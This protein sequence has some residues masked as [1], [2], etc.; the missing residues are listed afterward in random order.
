MLKL[1][2]SQQYEPLEVDQGQRGVTINVTLRLSGSVNVRSNS[3]V[4]RRDQQST[5]PPSEQCG[6]DLHATLTAFIAR[7]SCSLLI[8]GRWNQTDSRTRNLLMGWALKISRAYHLPRSHFWFNNKHLSDQN[9][10]LNSQIHIMYRG[11]HS[12]RI[13]PYNE[14]CIGHIMRPSV[15]NDKSGSR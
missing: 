12:H 1:I 15:Q 4:W 10:F 8:T 11:W 14:F 6:S 13:V 2:C 3:R 9:T 7:T 5:H